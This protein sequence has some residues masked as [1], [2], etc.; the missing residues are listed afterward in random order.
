M[1]GPLPWGDPDLVKRLSDWGLL[2]LQTLSFFS[3]YAKK[4]NFF[5]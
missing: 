5:S 1:A 2:R 4:K 3:S